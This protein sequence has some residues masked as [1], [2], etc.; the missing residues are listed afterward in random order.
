MTL[1]KL[2]TAML[3]AALI[4]RLFVLDARLAYLTKSTN[5]I[6]GVANACLAQLYPKPAG[7]KSHD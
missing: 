6:L 3:V 2:L 4:V 1:G 5:E 7:V